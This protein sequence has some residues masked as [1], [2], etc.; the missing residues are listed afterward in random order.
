MIKMLK[1]SDYLSQGDR[2]F[3]KKEKGIMKTK[4]ILVALFIYE[5]LLKGEKVK[6]D[7]VTDSMEVSSAT[8]K[9]AMS[10]IRCY[11]TEYQQEKELNYIKKEN[12]YELTEVQI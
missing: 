5:Q 9:R 12:L 6:K 10:D 7:E 8:F 4:R 3:P 11:L 1:Q 2:L